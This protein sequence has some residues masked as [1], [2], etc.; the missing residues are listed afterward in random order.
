MTP[1]LPLLV[2]LLLAG[3][4]SDP[5][6]PNRP[7]DHGRALGGLQITQP[8]VDDV[9]RFSGQHWTHQDAEDPAIAEEMLRIY[10]GHWATSARLG[11][12]PTLED[13]ARIWNG[14]PDGWRKPSTLGY[15]AKV[16]SAMN[17]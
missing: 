10:E 16:Q 14:G 5:R 17:R 4:E 11:H 2:G 9:D 3:V 12:E 15:W 7:G 8:V 13:M 6:N 1:L